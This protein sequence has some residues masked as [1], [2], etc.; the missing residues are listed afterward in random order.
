MGASISLLG[1]T[2]AKR[3]SVWVS[4]ACGSTWFILLCPPKTGSFLIGVFCARFPV[5]NRSESDE[6]IEVFGRTE[7]VYPETGDKGVPV[8]TICSKAGIGQAAY[9]N[10]KKK[11]AGLLPCE[12]PLDIRSLSATTLA[13]VHRGDLQCQPVALSPRLQVTSRI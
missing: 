6:G 5:G 9:F 7:G 3:S 12:T 10:W 2:F 13:Q 11:Y 8:A 4:E 1:Y